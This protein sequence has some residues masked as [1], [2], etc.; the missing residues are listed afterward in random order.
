MYADGA[1]VLLVWTRL[2]MPNGRL[3]VLERQPGDDAG[4]HSGLSD[5]VDNHWRQIAGAALLSTLL[6]VGSEVNAGVVAFATAV[7]R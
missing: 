7:D 1:G 6:S 5:E 4:G 2:I 3:I